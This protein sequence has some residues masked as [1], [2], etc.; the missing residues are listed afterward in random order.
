MAYLDRSNFRAGQSTNRTDSW[1]PRP[2]V[3]RQPTTTNKNPTSSL[4]KKCWTGCRYY[5]KRGD[6]HASQDWRRAVFI[7]TTFSVILVLLLGVLLPWWQNRWQNN[8]YALG[9]SDSG[10]IAKPNAAMA[11]NLIHDAKNQVYN[12]NAKFSPQSDGGVNDVKFGGAK[13]SATLSDD[14]TKGVTITDPYNQVDLTIKPKFHALPA[15][16]NQNQVQ[17]PIETGRG[18]LVYTA[19]A[20]GVKEDILLRQEAGDA[21]RFAYSL[22]LGD[23]YAAR[24][25]T[26]GSL[27]IYGSSLPI[28]GNVSTGTSKDAALLKKARQSAA[29]DKLLFSLPAPVIH[30]SGGHQGA[31]KAAY[32]LTGNTLTVT[33]SHLKQATYP[34]SI[35]PTVTVIAVTDFFRDTNIETNADFNAS[36][37]QVNR[38]SLKGGGIG[39]WAS[40]ST[41][42][43]TSRFLAGTAAYNGFLYS[44]G[45]GAQG[46]TS[47][48]T[49]ANYVEYTTITPS[50]PATFSAW[51]AGNSSGL[52]A[53]GLSRFKL[54]AYNGLLYAIDGS[55]TDTSCGTVSST[56]YYAVIQV[57][58]ILSNW[59]NVAGPT[60]ARCSL[61][62][63]A[64]NG[65]MYVA[66][67]KTGSLNSN[68]T[69]TVY[70]AQIRPDGSFGTWTSATALTTATYGGDLQAYNG[71]L[72]YIGG[73]QNGTLTNNAF[74]AAI[75]PTTGAV[76]NSAW[77]ATNNFATARENFGASF[78]TIN[79]GYLYL[80]TGC[81]AVNASQT[82]TASGNAQ[83]DTQV[84]QVNADGSLGQW[85]A[86]TGLSATTRVGANLLIW[87]NAPYNVGGCS[88][89]STTAIQCTTAVA[90]SQTATIRAVGETSSIQTA[91]AIPSATMAAV[92]LVN[93]GYIYVIGGCA[94]NSCDGSESARY[95]TS[96]A[97]LSS[98]GGL[99][100][101]G[102]TTVGTG[103]A[104][105]QTLPSTWCTSSSATTSVALHF[106]GETGNTNCTTTSFIQAGDHCGLA[107]AAG[108][109]Y[110][111]SIYI[112]GGYDGVN[113]T[114]N[115]YKITTDAANG[116]LPTTGWV[117]GGTLS[118]NRA[119]LGTFIQTTAGTTY[120]YGIGG[121]T[122][123]A[124]IGCSTYPVTVDRATISAAGVLGNFSTTGQMQLPTGVG[125]AT[126]G[127]ATYGGFIYLAGGTDN[128]N[129]Q[130]DTVSRAKL[131]SSGNIVSVVT[132]TSGGSWTDAAGKFALPRRRTVAFAANGYLYVTG[133]HDQADS[134][135]GSNGTT[136]G[137]TQIGK[138]SLS[139]TTGDIA[140]FITSANSFTARWNPM[141]VFQNGYAYVLGGCQAAANSYPPANCTGMLATN[142]YTQVYNADSNT[143]RAATTSANNLPDTLAGASAAVYN[144]YMY[145]AAGCGTYNLASTACN[146]QK[147]GFYYAQLNPDGSVGTWATVATSGLTATGFA[148]MAAVNGNLYFMGGIPG[149]SPS[150]AVLKSVIGANGVPGT[151][152]ATG[153]TALPAARVS[154]GSAVYNGVIYLTGGYDGTTHQATVWHSTIDASGNVTSWNSGSDT[155]FSGGRRDHATVAAGGYL[156]VLGGYDGTDFR[157]DAQYAQISSTGTVGA[158][159]GTRDLPLRMRQME[160]FAANGYVYVLAG[161]TGITTSSCLSTT[162]AAP[163]NNNGTIGDWS[164]GVASTFAAVLAPSVGYYNGYYYVVAGNSCANGTG[165]NTTVYGGQ[166]SQAIR[167]VY[168]RYIDLASNALPRQ[169]YILG[170][171]SVTSTNDID[172]WRLRYQSSVNIGTPNWGALTS[173]NPITFGYSTPLTL[174]PLDGSS[175]AQ[176]VSQYWFLTFDIDQTASFAFTDNT[177][178]NISKYD[179][180]Y[181]PGGTA[182][183]RNGRTFQDQTK[184]SLD[185]HP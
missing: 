56:I 55:T 67:G 146:G 114:T 2:S 180:Y 105:T 94:T 117:T 179:F 30:E 123:T 9:G 128:T 131:D 74:Y 5:L 142:E 33:A 111:G 106:D 141:V 102:I 63:A 170:T 121:C 110:N 80:A 36:A 151:F 3:P 71:Y 65:Y 90:T 69:N 61:G 40:A 83:S 81:S 183:L 144:G 172:K 73:N 46:T 6:V 62:A 93:N 21:L 99:V 162:Y 35:D 57:N 104:C 154:M 138:I 95:Q 20:G 76:Y 169:L 176:G 77:T 34:L 130:E 60:T 10:V 157:A 82:C 79:D 98:S 136:Y 28:N 84:A 168:S 37:N 22:E 171:N 53:G 184:Q 23:Q 107:G 70:Y 174:T 51:Q 16:Q 96:Y 112:I 78:T 126:F 27:G 64:Y 182:R 120:M 100:N 173:I 159:T 155:A 54:V 85:Y 58:G 97:L 24:V 49:G 13:I 116:S 15:K 103:A 145:V 8:A 175:V 52:P 29:K 92:T 127:L 38:G 143:N 178:P 31:A 129:A 68:S 133:G 41:S 91:T 156:Y 47:N 161:S 43:G 66:G 59:Q 119:E 1:A 135:G 118:A 25:E 14:P 109:T 165:T 115:T 26:G 42:Q 185:A 108:A 147:S 139:G 101:N 125:R 18:S 163:I 48:Y 177:Q 89:M 167:A 50:A 122:S 150:T 140:S 19:E 4:I 153:Q 148:S 17:Y 113:Y 75:N 32:S 87:N 39:S 132:G 181:A 137:N 149:A 88:A 166:Q 44:V 164:Q 45:G 7:A 124:G 86:S 152:S 134:T 160:S 158:W 12:F 11:A 72:Y